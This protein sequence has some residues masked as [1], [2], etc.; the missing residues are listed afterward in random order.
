MRRL[1]TACSIQLSAIGLLAQTIGGSAS[2]TGNA[3]L[4]GSAALAQPNIRT[5]TVTHTDFTPSQATLPGLPQYTINGTGTDEVGYQDGALLNGWMIYYPYQTTPSGSGD[6]FDAN[7]LAGWPHGVI[8]AYN[9]SQGMAGFGNAS[10]WAWFDLNTLPWYGKGTNANGGCV[11]G[12]RAGNQYCVTNPAGVPAGT[13]Y[14]SPGPSSVQPPNC[15]GLIGGEVGGVIAN[16]KLYMVPGE[17]APY[18]VLVMYDPSVGP[19]T[20]PAAYQTFAPPAEGTTMGAPYGWTEGCFDGRFVYYA[21]LADVINGISGNVFRY[22]TTQ[23]FSNLAT[24]GKTAAW[25]NYQMRNAS[26]S[27]LAGGFFDC[28]YDG[29]RYVYFTPY[30]NAVIVRYDTWNGGSGASGG[31]GFHSAANYTALNLTSLGQPGQ[32]AYT[33]QGNTANLAELIGG[34]RIVWDTAGSNQWLYLIPYAFDNGANPVNTALAIRVR[35]GVT[36]GGTW[37]P[38]DIASTATTGSAPNWEIADLGRVLGAN[39][40]WPSSWLTTYNP[41]NGS[42]AGASASRPGLPMTLPPRN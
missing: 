10:N 22:D 27:T 3:H 15:Q 42:Q 38:V 13:Y 18:P 14:V 24:G 17:R 32:P 7:M 1:T 9:E 31:D 5:L 39:F 19:I 4:S 2:L 36:T 34:S 29:N 20:N 35:V 30:T 37:Q 8:L 23:P 12:C 11:A 28:N 25:D 41:K 6:T 33:G 21:P 26:V 16:G 40:A